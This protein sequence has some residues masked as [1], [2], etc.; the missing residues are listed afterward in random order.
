VPPRLA[1]VFGLPPVAITAQVWA[2]AI[3]WPEFVPELLSFGPR[4]DNETHR[5]TEVM[6]MAA[7][8]YRN[9]PALTRMVFT[10][11]RTDPAG[12]THTVKPV[13]LVL[14]LHDGDNGE[15]VTTI[16]HAPTDTRK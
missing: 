2:D 8:A 13:R 16:S 11:L 6:C 1:H 14:D 4:A 5:I 7:L 9:N 12:T 3:A 15:I 10:V